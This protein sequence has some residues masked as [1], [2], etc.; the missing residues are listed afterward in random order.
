MQHLYK[1]ICLYT[2]I[3]PNL[4]FTIKDLWLNKYKSQN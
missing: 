2:A 1:S 3:I 4:E